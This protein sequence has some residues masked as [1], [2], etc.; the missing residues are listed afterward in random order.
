MLFGSERW[1]ESCKGA[2]VDLTQTC[3]LWS[4][5]DPSILTGPKHLDCLCSSQQ[6]QCAIEKAKFKYFSPMFATSHSGFS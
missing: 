4:C 5:L 1:N 6:Y 3:L 2:A